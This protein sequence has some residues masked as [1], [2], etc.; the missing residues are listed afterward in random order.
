MNWREHITA[1]PK[2]LV[3]KPIIRGTRLSV[4]FILGLVA[5]G[6]PEQEI[7]RNYQVTEDQVRA[8]AAYAQDRLTEERVYALAGV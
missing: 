6:W 7:I 1:D 8:C 5:Q 2:V 4:E 3:G